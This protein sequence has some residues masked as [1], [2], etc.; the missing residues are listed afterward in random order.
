MADYVL[1]CCSTCDL[2]P[3]HLERL[4]IKYVYFNY[5]LDGEQCKDDFGCTHPQRELYQRMLAGATVRTSQVS[6]GEYLDLW[7]P[8]LKAGKDVL[9]VALSSG[10]SGTYGSAHTA[11]DTICQEF[12]E[13]RIEVIDSLCASSGLGLLLDTLA[14]LRDGGMG[15]DELVAWAE[16]HKTE[17]NHWFFSSDLTFFVRGGRI[18]RAAGAMGG[19]LRICP[20]MEVDD[21]G[22]LQV[23][24]KVRTKARAQRRMVQ[25]MHELA[26][27]GDGYAQKVFISHSDCLEDA[28]G[29]GDRIERKFPHMNGHV[30]Y[31]D[32]GTTIG[33]HT[34]PGTV[35]LFFWGTRR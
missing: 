34:G 18:S 5:E 3:T 15:M 9:H 12:P 17:V 10:I 13:R 2:T 19:L 35:A 11:R 22:T 32:I 25:R 21:A 33:C 16:A 26:Q 1:T 27:G 30:H 31:F 29:V 14:G 4:E 24:E 7:R 8:L 28:H 20:V 23:R 6:T